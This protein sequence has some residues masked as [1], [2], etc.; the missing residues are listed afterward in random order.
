MRRLTPRRDRPQHG[1]FVGRK[2]IDSHA[3]HVVV[4]HRNPRFG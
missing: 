3:A 1:D 4:E 2:N